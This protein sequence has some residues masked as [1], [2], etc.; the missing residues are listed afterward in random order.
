[1]KKILSI[2]FTFTLLIS[3]AQNKTNLPIS[4][5]SKIEINP[6]S[7]N[8]RS[9]KPNSTMAA[10][11]NDNCSNAIQI[12]TLDGTCNGAYTTSGSTFDL[13]YFGCQYYTNQVWFYFVAQGPNFEITIQGGSIIGPQ[14]VLFS[15]SNICTST[16]TITYGLCSSA[17]FSS[18]VA[19]TNQN[20][21]NLLT[22]GQT[23]YFTVNARYND[24]SF[25][26]SVN[27][28]PANQIHTDCATA[29]IICANTSLSG[30]AELWG[31]CEL[32]TNTIGGCLGQWGE[33]NSTWFVIY[34]DPTSAANATL[35]FTISPSNGTD[36]YDYSIWK[37]A[38][39][40]LGSPTSCNFS[41]TVGNT[42]LKSGSASTSQGAGGTV[43][44]APLIT[45][46][47]DVYILLVNGYTPSSNNFS[48]NFSG[49]AI[50]GC[51]PPPIL[52]IELISFTAKY[53]GNYNEIKWS[54]ET[55]TSN[56]YFTIEKSQ[57][58]INFTEVTQIKGA[59]NSTEQLSYSYDDYNLEP[60]TL[61]YYR[62]SQTDYNGATKYFNIVSVDDSRVNATISKITNL[63]GQEV[64]QSYKG[65]IFIQYSDG[66]T[67]KKVN[68]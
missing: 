36:D 50:L 62:L 54:T 30:S 48:L 6:N 68:N 21:S 58:G 47:G 53:K 13:Y 52:P 14:V 26:V 41:S 17:A 66:L 33:V 23:Y 9:S 10:P 7:S 18:G 51:S 45:Q 43:W 49:S 22:V 3:N 5:N 1:M 12:T 63:L 28:P 29:N 15:G 19:I 67:I 2:L 56:N 59:G 24:G 4:E 32:T 27:N 38:T 44:N 31:N 65:V 35:T 39:C 8:F 64:D 34:V 57:D 37:G 20:C 40:T 11:S 16:P 42:G 25:C 46:P 60:P 55:E 61:V